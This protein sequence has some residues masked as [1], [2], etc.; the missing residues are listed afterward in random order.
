MQLLISFVG[1]LMLGVGVLHQLPH[2]VA[3]LAEENPAFALDWTSGWLMAGL[4]AMFLLLRMFHFHQHEP[5]DQAEPH[6]NCDP[7]SHDH[8]DHDR[9]YHGDTVRQHKPEDCSE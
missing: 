4:L 9:T 2:A 3:L 1:G 5:L 6:S 8:H 7:H